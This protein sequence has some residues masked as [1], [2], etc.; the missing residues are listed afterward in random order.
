MEPPPKDIS[1][2]SKALMFLKGNKHATVAIDI[3]LDAVIL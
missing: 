2:T 3:Y 1:T